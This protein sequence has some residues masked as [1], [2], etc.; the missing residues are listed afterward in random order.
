[1]RLGTLVT[2]IAQG[3]VNMNEHLVSDLGIGKI[4]ARC[5]QPYPHIPSVNSTRCPSSNRAQTIASSLGV[6]GRLG[7]S[8]EHMASTACGGTK[9]LH[10]LGGIGT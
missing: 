5:A 4:G 3:A 7:T 6:K 1:M 8:T 2:S 9:S 10:T